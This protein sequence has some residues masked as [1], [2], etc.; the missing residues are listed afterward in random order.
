MTDVI[1]EKGTNSVNGPCVLWKN[2]YLYLLKRCIYMSHDVGKLCIK[3]HTQTHPHRVDTWNSLL[4]T[5]I[6][7]CK[8]IDRN[9][10][11]LQIL[12]I[13]SRVKQSK[14]GPETMPFLN[15]MLMQLF[16]AFQ[17]QYQS[18]NIQRMAWLFW[19]V[20]AYGHQQMQMLPSP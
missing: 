1:F 8:S 5:Y 14:I 3:S 6:Y 2:P 19:Q 18:T 20:Q 10:K 17:L 7:I 4:I 16:F 12:F 9:K 15:T 13:D 11:T